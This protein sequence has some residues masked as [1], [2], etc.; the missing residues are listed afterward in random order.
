MKAR[1]IISRNSSVIYMSV[2][3]YPWKLHK[4]IGK[5]KR[6][7][8]LTFYGKLLD[9]ILEKIDGGHSLNSIDEKI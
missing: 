2:L 6:D 9:V 4:I 5:N 8:T 1:K 3:P 7:N